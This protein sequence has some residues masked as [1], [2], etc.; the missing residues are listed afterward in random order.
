[1]RLERH[2]INHNLVRTKASNV[3]G[4]NVMKESVCWDNFTDTTACE[5]IN[6]HTGGSIQ[7]DNI[8]DVHQ[9]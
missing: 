3:G 2:K 1:M 7:P 5:K 6:Q 8:T 9:L 4:F